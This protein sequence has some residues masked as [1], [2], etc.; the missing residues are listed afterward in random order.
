MKKKDF[1]IFFFFLKD[2]NSYPT[3][4]KDSLND[5]KTLNQTDCL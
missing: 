1:K 3:A 4:K 2:K 5:G